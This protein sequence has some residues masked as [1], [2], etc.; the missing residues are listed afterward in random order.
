MALDPKEGLYEHSQFAGLRNN[1]P[2]DRFEPGDLS[3]AQNVDVDDSQ[4]VTRRKG[5]GSAVVSGAC[6]SLWSD[7]STALAVQSETTLIQIMPSYATKTLRTGITTGRDMT[8]VS[9]A[10]RVYYSNGVETGVVD[11]GQSRSWG[12]A[13][14]SAQPIAAVTGGVLAPGRYQFA[15]TYLRTDGQESGT[16]V[17]GYIDL[18][19]T[20]GIALSAIPVPADPDVAAKM[21]YFSKRD[22]ETLYRVGAIGL[23]IT[24]FTYAM[25]ASMQVP[26]MTQHLAPPP[27]G[28]FVGRVGARL[29]VANGDTLYP[30]EPYAPELFDLR[31]AKRFDSRITMV[32]SIDTRIEGMWLGT[33]AAVVWLRGESP[34]KWEYDIAADYGVIPGSLAYIDGDAI[35][36]GALKG[37]PV[38][39]FATARGLCYGTSSGTF[40]NMT[41]D[42]FAYPIQDKG[43][44]VV[45]RHRGMIQGLVTMRGTEQAANVSS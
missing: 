42:R 18:A 36:N 4:R 3:V 29:L 23:T 44:A 38:A 17:A 13:P 31:K 32:E 25:E 2:V 7:G 5:H 6:K 26:L 1:V 41:W 19:S 10:G 43:A 39:F 37:S 9:M 40:E 33:D 15:V 21:V 11:N 30:S 35:G 28:D 34:E 8:Y 24:S 22:G 20:N 12:L 14:P 45:R 16:L 27:A